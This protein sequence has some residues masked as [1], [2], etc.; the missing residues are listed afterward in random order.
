ML[1]DELAINEVDI[2]YSAAKATY[3]KSQSTR[4]LTF[5]AFVHALL[6]ISKKLYDQALFVERNRRE[7]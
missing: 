3:K 2:I 6:L 1:P 5:E 7:R 4:G